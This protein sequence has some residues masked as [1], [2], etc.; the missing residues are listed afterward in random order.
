VGVES[1]GMAKKKQWPL[2]ES[3]L[4]ENFKQYLLF[5]LVVTVDQLISM[6]EEHN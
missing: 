2:Q 1:A 5:D 3:L 4:C 6:Y